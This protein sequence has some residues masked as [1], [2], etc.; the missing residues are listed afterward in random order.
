VKAERSTA[1]E[2]ADLIIR[3]F[4]QQATSCAH[5]IKKPAAFPIKEKHAGLVVG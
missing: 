2:D 3:S 4:M 5:A 1:F